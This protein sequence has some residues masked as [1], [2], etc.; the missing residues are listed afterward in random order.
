MTGGR[1]TVSRHFLSN[2]LGG[3]L[4]LAGL[5]AFGTARA[6][7][8][9]AETPFIVF[10]SN[11]TGSWEIFSVNADGS[12]ERQ[13]TKDES[14]NRDPAISNDGR[15][16]VWVRREGRAEEI[17]RMSRDGSGASVLVESGSWPA[18]LP[19]GRL[20]FTAKTEEGNPELRVGRVPA[21]GDDLIAEVA[22]VLPA[23]TIRNGSPQFIGASPD[24]NNVVFWSSHPRGTSVLDRSTGEERHVHGGCS[25]RFLPDGRHFLWV[26]TAGTFGIARIGAL[27][28]EA[29][30]YNVPTS[31]SHS[32]G[33]YPWLSPDYRWLVFTACP[34]NQHN[35]ETSNYQLFIQEF[36][37]GQ[38]EGEP[39]RLTNHS[40]TDRR[41]VLWHPETAGFLAVLADAG[42][43]EEIDS[44]LAERVPGLAAQADTAGRRMRA[45]SEWRAFFRGGAAKAFNLGRGAAFD[46]KLLTLD[47][48]EGAVSGEPLSVIT[49]AIRTKREFSVELSL[50]IPDRDQRGRRTILSLETKDREGNLVIAQAG[51]QVEVFFRRKDDEDPMQEEPHVRGKLPSEGFNHVIAAFKDGKLRLFIN[52]K[53][54]ASEEI[55]KSLAPWKSEPLLVLGNRLDGRSSWRGGIH[56]VIVR[57]RGTGTEEAG[58]N[59]STAKKDFR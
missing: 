26:Q 2:G 10:E 52:G 14:D 56:A 43:G 53:R 37:D 45:D 38:T 12:N 22:T 39:R 49:E 57:N 32:H 58:R 25:P 51:A 18:F 15:W 5:F 46:G 20:V 1:Y 35:Q 4:C 47:G 13:L 19:D 36:R 6:A 8:S 54:V 24:F 59:Y 34:A 50:D 55:R 16:I 31:L 44:L 11:R 28:E 17:W 7:E 40:G 30:F 41:P 29:T 9:A 48:G 33:Y 23:G 42:S 3:L 27:P 21:E